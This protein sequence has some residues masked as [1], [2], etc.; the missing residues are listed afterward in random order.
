MGVVPK[1]GGPQRPGESFLVIQNPWVAVPVIFQ[2]RSS[3]EGTTI[4]DEIMN[5]VNYNNQ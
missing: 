4:E 5:G 2:L 1:L 3:E